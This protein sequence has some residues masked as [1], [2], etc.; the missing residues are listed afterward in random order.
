MKVSD[1]RRI[2]LAFDSES[3]GYFGNSQATQEP[4]RYITF[5]WE[6]IENEISCMSPFCGTLSRILD[7]VARHQYFRVK[8]VTRSPT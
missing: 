7:F 3:S 5:H 8:S 6:I 2:K 4:R 1:R